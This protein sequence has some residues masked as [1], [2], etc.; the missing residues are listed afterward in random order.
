[1]RIYAASHCDDDDDGNE[2][3]LQRG[4]SKI[5]WKTI[6]FPAF[7]PSVPLN[8]FAR[9]KK[10]YG[11]RLLK[12]SKLKRRGWLPFQPLKLLL[13]LPTMKTRRDY[14]YLKPFF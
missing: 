1:M 3:L 7:F 8:T 4:D 2:S 10:A 5:K 14:L 13:K 12:V 6:H 11:L 9:K